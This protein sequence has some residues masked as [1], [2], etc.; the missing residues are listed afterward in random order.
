MKNMN[1]RDTQSVRNMDDLVVKTK[2]GHVKYNL[3]G[4]TVSSKKYGHVK[5]NIQGHSD[6]HSIIW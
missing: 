6:I 2:Y 5:N 4:H 3:Q 1:Y